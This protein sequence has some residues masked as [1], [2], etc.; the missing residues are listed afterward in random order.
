MRHAETKIQPV[1][2]MAAMPKHGTLPIR[3]HHSG[4]MYFLKM[5]ALA[6]VVS[7]MS[8]CS[9]SKNLA[10][11][12]DNG[13]VTASI[14]KPIEAEGIDSSDAEL[15]K[16][17]VVHAETESSPAT[18]LAWSNPDTGNKGTIMAIDKF[19][20]SHGQKCKKFQTSVD[21][22][23]GVSIYKGETCELREDSWVLSWF[24]RE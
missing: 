21:T 10:T 8:A 4:A 7:G 11:G 15:I 9:V 14:T 19:I 24:L 16:D 20:G 2:S 5:S 18:A 1:H 23:M 13:L 17:V 6:I 12:D 3:Q 22:F